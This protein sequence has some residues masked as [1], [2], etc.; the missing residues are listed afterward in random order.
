MNIAPDSAPIAE[1]GF[2]P[3]PLLGFGI[4][5]GRQ[6]EAGIG[7]P[8]I[9][10]EY[11]LLEALSESRTHEGNGFVRGTRGFSFSRHPSL[12]FLSIVF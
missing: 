12:C 6:N 7:A 4:K 9:Q 3:N 8:A 1:S 2:K 10:R 11:I 5:V